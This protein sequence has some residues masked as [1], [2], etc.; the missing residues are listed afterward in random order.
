MTAQIHQDYQPVA[1]QNNDLIQEVEAHFNEQ[2]KER[3]DM[4]S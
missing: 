4:I 1:S 2:L 3:E